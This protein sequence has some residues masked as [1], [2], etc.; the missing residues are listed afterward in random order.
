MR[1]RWFQAVAAEGPAGP[2]NR[3]VQTF[4]DEVGG[5]LRT[6]KSRW[7]LERACKRA[8]LRLVGWHTLRHT[9][10]SHLVMR[11]VSIVIVQ[12]LLG[13]VD[14]KTT[15]TC[16]LRLPGRRCGGSTAASAV[17]KPCPKPPRARPPR[18]DRRREDW[19]KRTGI[20]PAV[21]PLARSTTGFE[22]RAAHQ[23]RMRFRRA[24]WHRRRAR[25]NGRRRRQR[26]EVAGQAH[27]KPSAP[28][29]GSMSALAVSW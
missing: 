10:A 16:R 11:G 7:K 4:C 24:G 3:A 2:G 25:H 12:R 9:F 5:V 17:A 27:R 21:P 22:G 6:P 26:L 18:P 29:G 19:R 20:E 14:I 23:P 15:R 13:H 8:G 28:S 1:R